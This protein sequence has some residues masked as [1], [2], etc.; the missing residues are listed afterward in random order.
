MCT[1]AKA[2]IIDDKNIL[3]RENGQEVIL[4]VISPANAR[5]YIMSN[6]TDTFYDAKN[7]GV[8]VGFNLSVA[9]NAKCTLKVELRPNN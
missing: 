6:N 7:D 3:L 5:A 2:E 8:R 4:R 1:F 9:P